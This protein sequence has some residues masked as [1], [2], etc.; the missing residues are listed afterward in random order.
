MPSRRHRS[1]ESS[2]L[3][4][5]ASVLTVCRT[6]AWNEPSQAYTK[7]GLDPG[8]HARLAPIIMSPEVTGSRDDGN[9]FVG[10]TSP[11]TLRMRGV[12]SVLAV[13]SS[14]Q[15]KDGM[16]DPSLGRKAPAYEISL[17][18]P[19]FSCCAPD[20]LLESDFSRWSWPGPGSPR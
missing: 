8:A 12:M 10:R 6:D 20:L 14:Q 4:V 16:F 15:G 18:A 2:H 11:S 13:R 3:H 7:L 5:S 9:S 1:G 17:F 19:L